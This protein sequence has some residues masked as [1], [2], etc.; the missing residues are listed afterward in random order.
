LQVAQGV[1]GYFGRQ[2]HS[3]VPVS[4]CPLAGEGIN[5]V[6]AALSASR[7]FQTLLPMASAIELLENPNHNSIILLIHYQARPPIIRPTLSRALPLLEAVIF[8]VEGQ[9]RNVQ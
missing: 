3:L 7:P 9:A 5:S 1:I 4:R 6:L 8:S 2:S